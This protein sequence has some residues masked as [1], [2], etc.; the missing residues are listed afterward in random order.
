MH[1]TDTEKE[2]LSNSTLFLSGKAGSGKSHLLGTVVETNISMN[3]PTL[4][5]L[6]QAFLSSNSIENQILQHLSITNSFEEFLNTLNGISQETNRKIVIFIDAINENSYPDTWKHN[7]LGSIR[8]VEAHSNIK[9]VFSV[10]S[11]YWD[12]VVPSAINDAIQ[13]QSISVIK[14]K[15]FEPNLL[16]AAMKFFDHYKISFGV[17]DVLYADFQ[18]PLMLKQYCE[19]R[20]SSPVGLYEMYDRY[21]THT[22][23]EIKKVVESPITKIYCFI[24]CIRYHKRC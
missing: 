12:L 21:I 18:T 20:T 22:D 11:N 23:S 6:R 3:H 16:D 5:I 24:L 9:I 1:W 14:Y 10:R 4:L 7:L 19:T 8:K 13:D 15:G 2:F 17:L